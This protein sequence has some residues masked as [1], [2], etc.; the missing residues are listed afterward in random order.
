MIL[1]VLSII[2]CASSFVYT[3]YILC[4]L[5]YFLSSHNSKDESLR[6]VS[7]DNAIQSTLW[8]LLIDMLL[9]TIFIFQH[10]IM[11]NDFTKHIF[12]KLHIEYLSRS[13]YNACSSASLHFLI[14][15]WQQSPALTVW[16]ID[17]SNDTIWILFSGLH[18][19][20]WCI[21]YSGCIMMDIAELCGFKQVWYRVSGKN[22]PLDTKSK[23]LRRYMR[24]MRHP[25]FIGFLAI[26]WI[27]PFMSMDRI[28]LAIILTI[29]MVLIW[30]IDS[31]DYGYHIRYFRQKQIELS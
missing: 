4:N 1:N 31:E 15:K 13:I 18:V 16:K 11:A 25:S 8:S 12:F 2:V 26:L 7:D 10:S 24:H 17:T 14:N 5:T 19:F 6:V 29:Y 20:F 3:C 21:I 23:E 28:L 27:Y 30:T 9:L 22:S